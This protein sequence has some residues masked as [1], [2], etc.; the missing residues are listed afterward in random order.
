[1]S[2]F[3]SRK[4]SPTGNDM[5]STTQ[6]ITLR[7]QGFHE[8]NKRRTFLQD[9][10]W[11]KKRPEEEKDENY[12]RVVLNRHNSHDALDRKVNERDEPKATISRYRSDDTLD[13]ISDRNDATKT[14]KA[15]TL[16]NRLT[17]RNMSTFRSP[18]ATKTR[19][20]DSFSASTASTPAPSSATTPVK[21]KRQSWFPPP[22]PGYSA[23]PST[24]AG[25]REPT[26]HPPIPPKPSSSVSSPNQLRRENRQI[27]PPKPGVYTETNRSAER[28]IRS[29]DLENVVKVATSL[30]KTNKGEELDNLIKMN[31]NLNRNQGLDGLFRTNP[32]AEQTEKR[33]KSLEN[34][35]FMNTQTDKD[36]KGSHD[37][38]T[39][40]E[41]NARTDKTR[42]GGEDLDNLIKAKPKGSENA[43]GKQD[44]D[45]FIKVNP[46]TNKNIKRGQSL[47]NLIKVTPEVNRSNAGSKDLD[48]LI[49]VV[50]RT[51]KT[52][53]GGQSLDSLIKVSPETNGTNQS[54]KEGL[55]ELINVSPKAVKNM[56]RNQDLDKLI[57][58]NPETLTNNRRN[59]DL[60]NFIKV[61][62]AVT[63]SSQS[64]GLDNLIKV[65]SS[66]L[67]NPERDQDPKN[68]IEVNSNVPKNKNGRLDGQ[69]SGSTDALNKQLAGTPAHSYE[70]GKNLSFNAETRH[71]G[72]KDTFV[73]TRTY[74]ENSK[75]LKD[76][77]RENISGKYIQ[78][79]YS[80]S[81][82]SVIER[83][84]CTY[85]RKPLGTETKMILDELQICC[86]STCFKCEICKQPLENLQAGD[87]IW[88]YRQTIH[89][90]PCYSK[91]MAKWIQ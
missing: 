47:D 39:T 21:R 72:P 22:P 88:I 73:Y 59:Q 76:G 1:M 42:R 89:C 57:R 40:I 16:D 12:G 4:V 29:Q 27:C 61:S 34:L 71:A 32:K 11:I 55:D 19:P 5:K 64:E 65:K 53:Q 85:C 7:Q 80:T 14:Y 75:S 69:V 78:T 2:N 45:G 51:G 74:V 10:S 91:V 52:M 87:S 46:E 58:V 20:G 84:M 63:R 56:A 70:A 25:R 3:T 43:T 83:D 31:K 38:E 37:L 49:K 48:N 9:N 68:V 24:G 82:R 33:A 90:E 66:A 23:T 18:E 77:Y 35:I 79:V 60:D 86:H 50:P 17:N 36:G 67:S 54:R 6:G 41:V 62:P 13:R 81:D 15:N 26:V 28:N 30:Q 44:L 8:V